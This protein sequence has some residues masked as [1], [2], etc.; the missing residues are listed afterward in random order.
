MRRRRRRGPYHHD[1]DHQS[2]T[3]A[4]AST[5]DQ[6]GTTNL[7]IELAEPAQRHHAKPPQVQ[8][9]KLS[10]GPMLSAYIANNS[11]AAG[12]GGCLS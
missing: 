3:S 10:R 2:G 6:K 12:V 4:L 9:T 5:T 11:S 8:W 1:I 7:A